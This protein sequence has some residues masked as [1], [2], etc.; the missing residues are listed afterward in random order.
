MEAIQ[1]LEKK[2]NWK[3]KLKRRCIIAALLLGSVPLGIGI[4]AKVGMDIKKHYDEKSRL[5]AMATLTKKPVYENIVEALQGKNFSDAV[6]PSYAENFNEYRCLAEMMQRKKNVDKRIVLGLI[7]GGSTCWADAM[8]EEGY[9]GIVPLKPEEAGLEARTLKNDALCLDRAIDLFL[10]MVEENRYK[11][12]DIAVANFW[13]REWK[14]SEMQYVSNAR[15]AYDSRRHIS[16]M[17]DHRQRLHRHEIAL[18]REKKIEEFKKK[19]EWEKMSY[20]QQSQHSDFIARNKI[21]DRSML[22]W[23]KAVIEAN[24]RHK[25]GEQFTWIDL[26]DHNFADVIYATLAPMKGVELVKK[27]R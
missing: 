7:A 19:A 8:R 5:E 14:D 20:S 4:I 18:E 15:N 26:L 24:D 23:T 22:Y 17:H 13:N 25:A 27:V 9:Y 1:R 3:R 12:L 10:E 21:T 11:K 6:D 16:K 2:L